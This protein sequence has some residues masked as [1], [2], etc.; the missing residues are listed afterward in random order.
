MESPSEILYKQMTIEELEI[1][2]IS[3]I[4]SL[5]SQ[6]TEREHSF[7]L[8]QFG[9]IIERENIIQFYAYPSDNITKVV[10][11]LTLVVFYTPAGSH[12]R[13]EDVVVDNDYR[14]KSI[15]RIL[16]EMAIEESRNLK[17]K[18]VD[19]TSNPRREAANRLY[20]KMGFERRE[21]NV[22]RYINED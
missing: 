18:E 21:T 7:T 13:I 3:S 15:G 20:Q 22:Y 12:A 1:I 6:L 2:D 14:G 19:L 16:T 11:L 5:L 9:V 4:N 10:G 8:D 17:I